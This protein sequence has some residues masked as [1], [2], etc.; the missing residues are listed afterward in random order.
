MPEKKSQLSVAKQDFQQYVRKSVEAA[1]ALR[2]EL[3]LQA[4]VGT[5]EAM[6]HW[7]DLEKYLAHLDTLAHDLN[8]AAGAFG[9]RL[10]AIVRRAAPKRSVK[11][12]TKPIAKRAT[13]PVA[14]RSA[15]K[16]ASKKRIRR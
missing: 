2:D 13:K 5:E 8:H 11:R 6:S 14:K 1:K 9:E 16:R 4:H 7:A 12:A 15:K 10:L 3:K